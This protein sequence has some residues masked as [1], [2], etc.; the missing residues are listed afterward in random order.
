MGERQE[1]GLKLNFDGRLRLQ[2]QGASITSDAGLIACRELDE[3][4][5]LTEQA[6]G[7]LSEAR[8]GRNIQHDLVALL[9]QSVFSRLAGYEDTNDAERPSDR[10]PAPTP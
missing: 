2:F 6:N 9:R 5:G 1:D 10:P 3:V 8:T 4:L 7:M